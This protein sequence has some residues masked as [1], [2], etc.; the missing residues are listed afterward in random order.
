M[1]HTQKRGTEKRKRP[2]THTKWKRSGTD[3]AWEYPLGVA[4]PIIICHRTYPVT[5]QSLINTGLNFL[6]YM[7][8][9]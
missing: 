3:F 5:P 4:E 8:H 9:V 2:E 6:S 1:K 7:E